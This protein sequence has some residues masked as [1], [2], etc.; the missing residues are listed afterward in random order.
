MQFKILSH[1][2]LQV[3]T[4][5]TELVCDPWLLGSCYWRSWWNYP[6]VDEST[7]ASVKPS[8]IYL[9]HV[10]WDHF[11]G[12]SLRLFDEKTLI[13][14]PAGNYGRIRKDLVEMGYCNVVE[15]RHG[16]TF[17]IDDSVEITSFQ[18]G[19]FLD[20]A[21]VIKADGVTLFN[22]NDAKIMGLPLQQILKRFPNI[23][24]VFRSH[25]SANARLSF[26][27]TDGSNDAVDN[28]D[29]YVDSFAHFCRAT[30]A[31]YAIP[32]A[33]NHCF[34]H[35]EVFH[36]NETIQTPSSVEN[37][38]KINGIKSP[39]LRV[40]LTGDYWGNEEGFNIADCDYFENRTAHL[41][42]YQLAVAEKLDISYRQEARA[43]VRL[44]RAE[45]FFSSFSRSIPKPLKFLLIRDTLFLYVLTSG[46]ER[47]AYA[48]NIHTGEFVEESLAKINEYDAQIHTAT[49]IFNQCV[50]TDLFSHLAISKRVKYKVTKKTKPR[51]VWLNLFFNMYEYELLPLQKNFSKRSLIN[52]ILR[53]RELVLYFQL[54]CDLIFKRELQIHKY[55]R[56]QKPSSV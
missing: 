48:F 56:I 21:V 46:D 17:R 29:S 53:W 47:Y 35:K 51:V 19:P 50:T 54:A 27:Y 7:I 41:E 1:A 33:S 52:W 24:F 18:F 15:L 42:K 25:S 55:L 11:H 8:A 28:I 13:L 14:V 16:Q 23:D 44:A 4:E 3:T 10:H 9:T 20:S 32:F 45:E 2:G 43:R 31:R 5:T 49:R 36:Y 30:G 34:L 38:W 40:M 12:P 22:A 39:A 26:E 37:H 6:P